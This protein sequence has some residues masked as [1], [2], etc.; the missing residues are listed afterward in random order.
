MSEAVVEQEQ[1]NQSVGEGQDAKKQVVKDI[2]C[3]LNSFNFDSLFF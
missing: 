3:N 2:L 1:P